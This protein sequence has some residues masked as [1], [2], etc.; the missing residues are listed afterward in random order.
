GLVAIGLGIA[1]LVQIG[2]NP[3]LTGKGLAIAGIALPI[4][5][6]GVVS[7]MAAI[8]I[9]NFIKFQARSKQAECKYNLKSA[10]TAEKSYYQENERYTSSISDAGFSPERGNRYAYFFDVR[11]PMQDRSSAGISREDGAETGVN[12]DTFKYPRTRPLTFND[13]GVRIAGDVR[14]GVQGKCPDCSFVA[15]CAGN[16]DGDQ[17]LDVWSISTEDRT[18]AKGEVIP[19]GSPYCDVNDVND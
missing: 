2:N 1:A 10:F 18:S 11:G 19:A 8:A 7:L 9:P 5:L 17:T 14:P 6:G 16:L 13:V 15:V 3:A 4:A 12:I